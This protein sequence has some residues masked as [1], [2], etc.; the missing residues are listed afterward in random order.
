MVVFVK[1]KSLDS[2]LTNMCTKLHRFPKVSV[3]ALACV[4]LFIVISI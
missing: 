1:K 4:Q 2:K 3:P